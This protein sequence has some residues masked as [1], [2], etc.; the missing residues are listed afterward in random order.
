MASRSKSPGAWSFVSPPPKEIEGKTELPVGLLPSPNL[1]LTPSMRGARKS[2]GRPKM[3]GGK[4]TAKSRSTARSRA[5][6][7]TGSDLPPQLNTT[8][9]FRH[10]YRF[11]VTTAVT[12][13]PV[14]LGS[15]M[16]ALGGMVTVANS[17][18]ATWTSTFQIRRFVAWPPQN[19]GADLVY[20]NW[21]AAATSGYVKDEQMIQTLPDGITV[22]KGMVFR[23]PA[24]SL[25]SD[26]LSNGLAATVQVVYIT[27]PAGAIIDLEVAQ[28]LVN[29]LNNINLSITVGAV[30]GSVYYLALDGATANKIQ[31]FGLPST[32]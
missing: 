15:I 4:K 23:P 19:A 21:S 26:W 18:F 17:A 7:G 5:R 12:S 24:K 28:T 8:P 6:T 2:V 25:A 13:Q 16:G 22:T 11:R 32:H 30:L 3:K 10:T 1:G 14:T 20:L 31:P 29:S 27:A 9:T